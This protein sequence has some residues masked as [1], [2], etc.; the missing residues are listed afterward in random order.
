MRLI[1]TFLLTIYMLYKQRRRAWECDW[2]YARS[3]DGW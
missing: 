3:K 2:V 1:I